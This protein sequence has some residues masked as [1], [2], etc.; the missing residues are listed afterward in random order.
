MAAPPPAMHANFQC[1]I[2]AQVGTVFHLL[3]ADPACLCA[4]RSARSRASATSWRSWRQRRRRATTGALWTTRATRW[5]GD[6][7][8][9]TRVDEG[10]VDAWSQAVT[11]AAVDWNRTDG[12]SNAETLQSELPSKR[13]SWLPVTGLIAMSIDRSPDSE[14]HRMSI[15]F[16]KYGKGG[17][18]QPCAIIGWLYAMPSIYA[19]AR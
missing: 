2:D 18:V 10:P 17:A 15:S 14:L 4:C 3:Y 13:W 11:E 9:M 8:G 7:R 6:H 1:P 16:G 12:K 5:T 19:W